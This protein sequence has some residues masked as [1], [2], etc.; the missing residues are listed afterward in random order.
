MFVVMN[1]FLFYRVL[2]SDG[3]L[4]ER[5]AQTA[6]TDRLVDTSE[7][8]WHKILYRSYHDFHLIHFST[9]FA[10]IYNSSDKNLEL[11]NM[12]CN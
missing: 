5:L 1:F 12:A 7:S 4:G 11:V 2:A 3:I 6:A 9:L 8:S 10:S